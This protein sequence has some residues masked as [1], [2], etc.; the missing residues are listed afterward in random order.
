MPTPRYRAIASGSSVD[1]SL[2]GE[3]RAAAFRNSRRVVSG[4]VGINDVV[5]DRDTLDRIK[6]GAVIKTQAQVEADR[7]Y[8]AKIR[9]EKMK[10]AGER[11]ARMKELEKRAT[12]MAKKSDMEIEAEGIAEAR[13][14]MANEQMDKNSDTVKL[15]NSMAARAV[16]FSVR[17]K[18]L[19]EKEDREKVEMEMDRRLDIMM[20]IDRVKDIQRR[21][22]IET[23]KL[24]KRRDDGKIITSQMEANKHKRLLEAEMRDQEAQQMVKQFQRYAE[25]DE[26]KAKERA[27]EQAKARE[28]V[29]R[30]NEESIQAKIAAK[31]AVK[32]EMED[33]L[34]YQA[35]RDAEIAQR[36]AEEEEAARLKKERQKKLL[37][38]QERAQ[39]TAGALD[40]LRA[41]RAA[42]EAERRA[43]RS[44][45]EKA[46]KS[47]ADVQ[48][49]LASRAK[50]AADKKKR[51]ELAAV[52]AEEE[53]RQGLLY[54]KKMDDRE[55]ADANHKRMMADNHRIALHNQIDERAKARS[56]GRSDKFAD[57]KKFMDDMHREEAKLKVI[58]DK[59]VNDLI[60]NGVDARYLSE[61]TNVD[62]GKILR[63]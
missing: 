40:E 31:E 58:R 12:A 26:I 33:I 28:A 13:R 53:V 27:V 8:A 63:R 37:E 21:E 41:R 15:L 42:E 25:L 6:N 30:A 36:E 29:M 57:G 14:L 7:E 60:S 5:V 35:K 34:L 22:E 2:F 16:A 19:K 52:E 9:A 46:A 11:K 4:P 1:E 43:R 45:K 18:Q 50:Q 39:N 10:V 51:A 55:A 62:I 61:M 59:M 54:M 47:R 17:D 20:E 23:E 49:L 3:S 24:R 32:K 48:D 56:D 38:Q 44:E